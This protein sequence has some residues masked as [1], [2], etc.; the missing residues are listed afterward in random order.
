MKWKSEVTIAKVALVSSRITWSY[1]LLIVLCGSLDAVLRYFKLEWQWLNV[2]GSF[3]TIVALLLLIISW[4]MPGILILLGVPWVAHAWIRG[5]NPITV[6]S[7][8]WEQMSSERKTSIYLYSI[9]IS[10][11]TI[12]AI[13]VFTL[14]NLQ[15]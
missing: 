1:I 3:L 11:F 12:F 9:L 8:P 15:Q 14:F 6:P 2:I 5:I 4:I 7:T 13:V 10:G